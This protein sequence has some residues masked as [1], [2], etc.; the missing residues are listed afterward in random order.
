MSL[1]IWMGDPPDYEREFDPDWQDPRGQYWEKPPH[2]PEVK[3][4]FGSWYRC[5]WVDSI[6]PYLRQRMDDG[7]RV[8]NPRLERCDD[9]LI[10]DAVLYY[11][12]EQDAYVAEVLKAQAELREAEMKRRQAAQ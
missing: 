5:A 6:R 12:A 10:L 7:G 11:E 8:A 4:C 2:D 9:R 1:P 3:A